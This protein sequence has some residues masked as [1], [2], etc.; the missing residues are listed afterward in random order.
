MSCS[1]KV[2]NAQA[3]VTQLETECTIVCII[4]SCHFHC[5]NIRLKFCL[6]IPVK[7][8][9]IP[10]SYLLKLFIHCWQLMIYHFFHRT[11]SLPIMLCRINKSNL[12]KYFFFNWKISESLKKCIMRSASTVWH[13]GKLTSIHCW[14][15]ASSRFV[16]M[17]HSWGRY[18]ELLVLL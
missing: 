9:I 1:S 11:N 15:D 8:K 7:K 13:P 4:I 10:R 2:I 14:K 16:F 12:I 3:N 17:S 6:I 5:N 18:F